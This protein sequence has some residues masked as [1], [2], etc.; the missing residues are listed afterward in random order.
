[1]GF[2]PERLIMIAASFPGPDDGTRPRTAHPHAHPRTPA[3]VQYCA[4]HRRYPGGSN[5]LAITT[6][7]AAQWV[8]T[9]RWQNPKPEKKTY[10]VKVTLGDIPGGG[11]LFRCLSRD[12]G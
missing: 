9:S 8:T 3:L 6:T 2:I 7:G 4:G 1:M 5:L 10:T 12:P 11:L